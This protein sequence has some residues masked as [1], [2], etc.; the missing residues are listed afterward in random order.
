[1]VF[2]FATAALLGAQPA[3]DFSQFEVASIRLSGPQSVRN[4]DG[5]PGHPDPTHYVYTRA[6]LLDL[7]AVAWD[8]QYF[9]ISGSA[10]E[11]DEFDLEVREPPGATKEQFRQMMQN[12]L[13]ERFHL[14]SHPEKKEYPVYALGVAKG[15]SKINPTLPAVVGPGFPPISRNEPGV[16]ATMSPQGI[17]LI[18]VQQ[19]I[20]ILARLLRTD[21]PL[22]LDETGLTGNYSFTLWY[23]DPTTLAGPGVNPGEAPD[24]FTAVREQLG[25][26]LIAKKELLDGLVVDSVDRLPTEN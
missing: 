5:G 1:M 25:L 14:K 21:R 20:S 10:L 12:F 2:A 15:G 16:A 4:S 8:L 23:A 18:A 6:H 17:N 3:P 26:E 9:R 13:S 24:L 7:I 19:P 11:R 22:V